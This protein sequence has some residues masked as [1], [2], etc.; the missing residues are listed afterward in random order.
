MPQDIRDA[1]AI[2]VVDDETQR[3]YYWLRVELNRFKEREE[4]Y[5]DS[6]QVDGHAVRKPTEVSDCEDAEEEEEESD[7]EDFDE[8]RSDVDS[9]NYCNSKVESEKDSGY[10]DAA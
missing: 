7:E 2:I 1:D 9:D 5:W 6:W 8:E 10:S 3:Q 4:Q